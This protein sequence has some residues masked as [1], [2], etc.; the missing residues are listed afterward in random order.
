VILDE[1]RCRTVIYQ[2]FP[3]L[4]VRSL[5]YFNSGWDYELWEINDELL[6]RFPLREECATWLPAEARLLPL[7]ATRLPAPIPEPLLVSSG[8]EAFEWPFFAYRKLGGTPLRDLELDVDAQAL[9][10]GEIG[11]FVS[12]L[13]AVPIEVATSL[14]VPAYDTT[15]WRDMYQRF[16]NDLRP[17][18]APLLARH[19]QRVV[20][21]FWDGY[22]ENDE[23][24]AFEPALTHSDLDGEHLLVHNERVSGV[25]DF[26]DVRVG[27]PAL[28]FAGWERPFRQLV[29]AAYGSDHTG[30]L[31]ARADTYRDKI[32]PFH[33]VNY[34]L[35]TDKRWL[36]E[37]LAAVRKA[38]AVKSINS[39]L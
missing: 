19:E 6:F 10:A 23:N 17:N 32:G 28:D 18:M 37:G 36:D 1:A 14:G 26:G 7:L 22:L 3:E 25:I 30:V 35:K 38:L 9:V 39:M 16:W 15:S 24:F 11:E 21:G 2:A 27:D 33:A 4:T 20:D 12:T 29:L 34:G 8:V 13:H 31:S 5:R